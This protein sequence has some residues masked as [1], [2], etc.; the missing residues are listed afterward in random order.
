MQSALLNCF[1][2]PDCMDP[3]LV[4][5]G[6]NMNCLPH[7]TCAS[8][9]VNGGYVLRFSK[10]QC[11]ATFKF[12]DNKFVDSVDSTFKRPRY[13]FS[14]LNRFTLG[15]C[16]KGNEKIKTVSTLNRARYVHTHISDGY[17]TSS[18]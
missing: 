7:A 1:W 14:L 8:S 17:S 3:V 13:S 12:Y 4:H 15:H 2:K 11:Y 6:S 9:I 5:F 10:V 18:V 16:L